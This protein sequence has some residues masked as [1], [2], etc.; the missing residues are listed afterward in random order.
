MDDIE[1]LMEEAVE[2]ARK[3]Y[4]ELGLNPDETLASFGVEVKKE[5]AKE[6]QGEGGE[7]VAVELPPPPQPYVIDPARPYQSLRQLAERDQQILQAIRTLA[8][9]ERAKEERRRIAELEAE[10]A[11]LRRQQAEMLIAA[12]PEEER[13][14]RLEK[15]EQFRALYEQAQQEV[16]DPAAAVESIE[17]ESQVESVLDRYR[18]VLPQWRLDQVV[19]AMSPGGCMNCSA[20]GGEPHGILDH[21]EHGNELSPVAAILRLNDMLER[22]SAPLRQLAAMRYAPQPAASAA[23]PSQPSPAPVAQQ[24]PTAANVAKAVEE[25]RN[26]RLAA[27]PD[28]SDTRAVAGSGRRPVTIEEFSSMSM[29]EILARW[30]NPG[31]TLRAVESGEIILSPGATF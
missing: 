17:I 22:E 18:D 31:D 28:V 3:Q 25:F 16:P 23:V 21:D 11:A 5:E 14:E 20:L 30:P 2:N 15:D 10:L 19:A 7:S 6:E 24:S 27:N 26:P 9:R 13:K 12:V 4:E 8:G 29:D 1:Q